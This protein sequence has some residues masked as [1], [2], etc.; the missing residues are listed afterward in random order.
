MRSVLLI[1]SIT[2]KEALRRWVWLWVIFI[3]GGMVLMDLIIPN[4]MSNRGNMRGLSDEQMMRQGI[5][6]ASWVG[7]R[8]ILFF[9]SIIAIVLAAGQISA[10]ID[11]GVLSTILPKPIMRWQVMLGKWIGV[12]FFPWSVMVTCVLLNWLLL[13]LLYR[14]QPAEMPP[15][16]VIGVMLL[17]PALYGTITLAFSSFANMVFALLLTVTLYAVTYIG[18]VVISVIARL[19]QSKGLENLQ[20]LS[21]WIIPHDR[22]SRWLGSYDTSIFAQANR[23]V[24][25]LP[26][27][28]T[29]DKAYIFLYMVAF[30]A[31]GAF[32]FSR[33]DVN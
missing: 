6:I 3:I 30:F 12:V 4:A 27:A 25:N 18:D 7:I 2:L 8:I 32:I 26:S 19:T 10:E 21:G 29:W 5:L 9:T 17:Y 13:S 33:R 15:W 23:Q 20:A 22:L 11:K 14:G 16:P 28:D 1:S 24:V 31:L